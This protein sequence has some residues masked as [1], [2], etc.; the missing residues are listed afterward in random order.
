MWNIFSEW[1]LVTVGRMERV[2]LKVRQRSQEPHQVL[3]KPSTSERRQ[4]LLRQLHRENGVC[5]IE[6][7]LLN[8]ERKGCRGNA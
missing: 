4:G 5:F 8:I 2:F 6:E 1:Q 3:H 7:G